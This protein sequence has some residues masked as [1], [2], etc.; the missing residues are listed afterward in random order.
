MY[1]TTTRRNTVR[2]RIIAV[3]VMKLEWR[4]A[5]ERATDPTSRHARPGEVRRVRAPR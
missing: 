1:H 2:D 5:R 3:E 4:Q